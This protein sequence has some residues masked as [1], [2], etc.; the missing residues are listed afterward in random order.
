MLGLPLTKFPPKG[1]LTHRAYGN[2]K[3][4]SGHYFYI[5]G[6]KLSR[7]QATRNRTQLLTLFAL[8]ISDRNGFVGLFY[9]D[10][11]LHFVTQPADSEEGPTMFY[12]WQNEAYVFSKIGYLLTHFIVIV[13]ALF[14]NLWYSV[15]NFK[16]L[17]FRLVITG[18]DPISLM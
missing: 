7:L 1:H 2:S 12:I 11:H 10:R 17:S 16:R 14:D 9:R 6:R 4:Y 18:F 15:L 5:S 3:G 8:R 13:M